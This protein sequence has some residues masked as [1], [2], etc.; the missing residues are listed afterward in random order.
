MPKVCTKTRFTL[1]HTQH[2]Q[3]PLVEGGFVS[4]VQQAMLFTYAHRVPPVEAGRD[5]H[6]I[7]EK[8]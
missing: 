4:K 6:T 1:F 2:T 7:Q 8:V 5:T 3:N